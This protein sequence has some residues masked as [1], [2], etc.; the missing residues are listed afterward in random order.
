MNNQKVELL[1]PAG[2]LEKLKIA[3]KYGA[4]AV[5]A[6]VSHFSLR[7]RAGKEFTFETF[8]EGI[9]YAHA[10]ITLLAPLPCSIRAKRPLPSAT[11][12]PILASPD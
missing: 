3:I 2:N 8:K 10:R 5:Y 7:I 4:D 11:R 6:G 1:S 9:D 12:S